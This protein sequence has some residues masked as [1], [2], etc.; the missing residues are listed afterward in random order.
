MG[1]KV[2]HAHYSSKLVLDHV[3]VVA[4]ECLAT[5]QGSFKLLY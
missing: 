5:G 4:I 2:C 1:A 3:N